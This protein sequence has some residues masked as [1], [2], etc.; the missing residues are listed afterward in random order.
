MP[1]ADPAKK[2]TSGKPAAKPATKP[3]VK[4]ATKPD[5]RLA[6]KPAKRTKQQTTAAETEAKRME[7]AELQ[8]ALLL[9]AKEELK[10]YSQSQKK[11]KQEA[12]KADEDLHNKKTA[13]LRDILKQMAENRAKDQQGLAAFLCIDWRNSWR[14]AE[15]LTYELGLQVVQKRTVAPR[16][17][18]S[19]V[20]PKVI[21][22]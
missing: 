7:A 11:N 3:V 22:R 14:S 1:A 20:L 21:M 8:T 9:N 2:R 10:S 15:M 16:S 5:A 19:A 13:I 18:K 6:A 12:G 17:R 4:S